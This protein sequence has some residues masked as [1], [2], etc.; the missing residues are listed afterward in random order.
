ME[1]IKVKQVSNYETFLDSGIKK[2]FYINRTYELNKNLCYSF[3]YLE[4]LEKIIQ[5][6]ELNFVVKSQILKTYILT[7]MSIVEGIL[8]YL[9]KS[10]DIQ[11]KE[12][13]K[14]LKVYKSNEQ[15]INGEKI[16]V[17][18]HVL[19]KL[20]NPISVDMN[21]DSM[22]KKA[23]SKRLL[24]KNEN[25]YKKLNHLRKLR[26]KIHIHIAEYLQHD[27]NSFKTSDYELMKSILLSIVQSNIFKPSIKKVDEVFDFLYPQE[28]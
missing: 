18:T 26:N 25:I 7:G 24:G 17:E 27:F 3:I 20:N 10:K 4:Y 8:F 11:K 1:N 23:E 13:Y 21:L 14:L 12:D 15:E 9:L 22:L 6:Q 28:N 2:N 16:K 5:E 19:G